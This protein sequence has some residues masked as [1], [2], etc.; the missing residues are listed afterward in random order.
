MF[1][2]QLGD[3]LHYAEQ[4]QAVDT[5]GIPPTSHAAGAPVERARPT[6]PCLD[7]DDVLAPRPMLRRTPGC[8]EYHESSGDGVR[9]RDSR[10]HPQRWSFGSEVCQATL[11]RIEALDP[12]LNAFHSSRRSAPWPAPPASMPAARRTATCRS[13]ASPSRSRTTSARAAAARPPASKILEALRA[14]IRRDRRRAARSRRRGHRRQDQLR[15]VRDG[16]VHGELRLRP[17]AQSVGPRAHAGRI[18]RRVGGGGR[19][20]HGAGRARLGHRRLDPP[21]RRALRRRRPEADLRAR[22]A[23]RA[24][25]VRLVARSDRAAGDARS[26]DAALPA[27]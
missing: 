26:R 8:S 6:C 24:P 13:S 22:V 5:S 23:L 4:V 3:I 12:V 20:R 1:T 17:D 2:R 21:A 19:G 27:R 11:T 14:A 10:V 18:E 9:A 15:R 25:R 16:L 7:R